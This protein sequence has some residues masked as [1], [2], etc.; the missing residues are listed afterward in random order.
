MAKRY[1]ALL[2]QKLD[3]RFQVLL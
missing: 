2:M 3:N 1:N